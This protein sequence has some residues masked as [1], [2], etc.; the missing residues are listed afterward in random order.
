[1]HFVSYLENMEG[2]D[3]ESDNVQETLDDD[4]WRRCRI[5]QGTSDMDVR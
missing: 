5:C 3:A 2:S 4:D 1:M